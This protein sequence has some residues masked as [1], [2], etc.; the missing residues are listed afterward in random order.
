MRVAQ[1]CAEVS[2]NAKGRKAK[3]GDTEAVGGENRLE[4]IV[5]YGP[6]IAIEM[7]AKGTGYRKREHILLDEGQNEN[8]REDGTSQHA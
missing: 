7:R 1:K 2:S 6:E 4:R 8:E 3:G 5:D